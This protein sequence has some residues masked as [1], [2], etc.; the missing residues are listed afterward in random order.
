MF[1]INK[2]ALRKKADLR[3]K[4]PATRVAGLGRVNGLLVGGAAPGNAEANA[5][6]G[7]RLYLSRPLALDR[8]RRPDARRV[9]RQIGD[10]DPLAAAHEAG[11]KQQPHGRAVAHPVEIADLGDDL[12]G[13]V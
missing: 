2:S 10:I 4:K 9:E 6:N 7:V 1:V 11:G 13:L 12:S 3:K 8:L 5:R